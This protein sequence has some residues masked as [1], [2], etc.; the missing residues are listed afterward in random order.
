MRW[1]ASSKGLCARLALVLLGVLGGML[2]AEAALRTSGWR[3]QF[4]GADALIG[5]VLEPNFQRSVPVHGFPGGSV[6]LRTNNVGLRRDT[7]V[8]LAKPAGTARILVLGDSQA[9]GIVPN[10]DTFS[11]RIERA[12]NRSQGGQPASASRYGTPP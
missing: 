7:D 5:Y 11:S 3:R 2:V 10:G 6:V 8:P 1:L 4:A 9:E 12:L